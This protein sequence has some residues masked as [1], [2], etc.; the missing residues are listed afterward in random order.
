MSRHCRAV[1]LTPL[2]P[3]FR[4]FCLTGLLAGTCSGRGRPLYEIRSANIRGAALR[5]LMTP[6]TVP[7]RLCARGREPGQA[8]GTQHH[9]HTTCTRITTQG[10]VGRRQRGRAGTQ[11]QPRQRVGVAGWLVHVAGQTTQG[12]RVAARPGCEGGKVAC[13]CDHA[14]GY[15]RSYRAKALAWSNMR[16]SP[17][18]ALVLLLQQAKPFS[19]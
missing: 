9:H 7:R 4:R 12:R 18:C 17:A 2:L 5:S 3:I 15:G 16:K 8:P 14:I 10:R 13:T 6:L 1:A 19:L 11:D